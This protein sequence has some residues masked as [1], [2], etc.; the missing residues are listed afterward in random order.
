MNIQKNCLTALS[1]FSGHRFL[2]LIG[3]LCLAS[4]A[5]AQKIDVLYNFSGGADGGYPQ[6]G[7]IRDPQGN[8]Y[9][10]AAG[11]Q[12]VSNGY[13]IIFEITSAGGGKVLYRF[14]GGSDGCS[15]MAALIRDSAGNLYGTAAGGGTGS[16]ASGYGTV[17]ELSAG[18]TFSVLYTFTGGADGGTPEAPLFRDRSGDLYGTTYA[19][20]A[21][22]D[23][24]VFEIPADGAETVLHSFSGSDG[25]HPTA[26]LVRDSSGNLYGTTVDGG[27]SA[28]TNGCGVIYEINST[29][30]ESTLFSFAG[31][32]KGMFPYGG[33]TWSVDGTLYGTTSVFGGSGACELGC[34]TVFSITT[35]GTQKVVHDFSGADGKAPDAG[36]VLDAQGDLYGAA[37]QGG[38]YDA[39][40]VFEV[41]AAGQETTLYNFTGAGDGSN[42][43]S[44]LLRDSN[45]NLYGTTEFGG[46]SGYGTVFRVTP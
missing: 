33:L 40:T 13:G 36:L 37:F 10:T 5:I 24:T 19:G 23:G 3:F 31:G 35:T 42:P 45:G 8:L 21:S 9:G 29:G 25:A 41:N 4:A 18:G 6:A 16:C 1:I 20:G 46:A 43:H 26:G 38:V 39:G 44:T 14:T 7:L 30:A 32:T 17:F 2:A 28:C 22:G 27:S 15:P 12:G 34:G 11:D